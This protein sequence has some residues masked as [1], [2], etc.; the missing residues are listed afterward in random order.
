MN[1]ISQNKKNKLFEKVDIETAKNAII[2]RNFKE[3]YNERIKRN[4]NRS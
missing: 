2:Y 4:K 1:N 3:V